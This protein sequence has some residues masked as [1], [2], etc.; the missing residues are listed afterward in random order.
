M[1]GFMCSFVG[2]KVPCGI[3]EKF[4]W[5]ETKVIDFESDATAEVK[6]IIDGPRGRFSILYL[7]HM[8]KSKIT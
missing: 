8:T 1:N 3:F 5:T 7:V 2:L 4:T 6:K